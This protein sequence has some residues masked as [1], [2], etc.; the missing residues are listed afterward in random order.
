MWSKP[1]NA[2]IFGCIVKENDAKRQSFTLLL[3]LLIIQS[4]IDILISGMS[5]KTAETVKTQKTAFQRC[6]KAFEFHSVNC[7]W[8]YNFLVIMMTFLTKSLS[9]F[10]AVRKIA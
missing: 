3:Q 2:H 7:F 9:Y 8:W 5:E 1:D 4:N 6:G 10:A